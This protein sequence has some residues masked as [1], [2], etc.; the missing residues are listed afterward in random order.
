MVVAII[1]SIK[2]IKPIEKLCI[3]IARP[4]TIKKA[5]NPVRSGHGLG[6]TR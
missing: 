1:P 5:V 2:S 6:S 3:C 4:Y